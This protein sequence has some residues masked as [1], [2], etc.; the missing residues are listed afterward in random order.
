MGATYTIIKVHMY[1]SSI[2]NGGH[3]TK[4]K[5]GKAEANTTLQSNYPPI[6]N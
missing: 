5:I 3:E 1:S 2:L 6:K 4:S